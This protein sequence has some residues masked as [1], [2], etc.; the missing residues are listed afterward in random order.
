MDLA[1]LPS[2]QFL[3]GGGETFH[4][5]EA[6]LLDTF[7]SQDTCCLEGDSTGSVGE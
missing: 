1:A 7:L 4:S 5:T 2:L 6:S 3:G